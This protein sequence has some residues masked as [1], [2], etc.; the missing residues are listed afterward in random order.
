MIQ[1]KNKSK[2]D[3]KKDTKKNTKKETKKKWYLIYNQKSN[4]LL[5]L[6]AS[7]FWDC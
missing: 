4:E 6:D 3:S 5:S 2:K 7:G 1:K